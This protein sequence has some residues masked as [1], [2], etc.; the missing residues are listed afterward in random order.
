MTR[1]PSTLQDAVT[2]LRDKRNGTILVRGAVDFL[3]V[4]LLE[5][6]IIQKLADTPGKT[7]HHKVNDV[8]IASFEV[9]ASFHTLIPMLRRITAGRLRHMPPLD[10]TSVMGMLTIHD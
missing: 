9:C 1:P 8:M 10:I 3:V 5:R 4:V 6:D 7:L 2:A